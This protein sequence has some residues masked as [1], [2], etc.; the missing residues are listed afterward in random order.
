MKHW[1]NQI[2]KE[3]LLSKIAFF[4][5]CTTYLLMITVIAILDL[6]IIGKV[7]IIFMYLVSF[8]ISVESH[9]SSVRSSEGEK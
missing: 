4:C 2:K 6:Y 5:L 8:W 3:S 9:F 7:A 1:M